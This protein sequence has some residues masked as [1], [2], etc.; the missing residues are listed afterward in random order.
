MRSS[1][2]VLRLLDTKIE[3]TLTCLR[4]YAQGVIHHMVEYQEGVPEHAPRTTLLEHY[5][6]GTY[7]SPLGIH[8][9]VV[10]TDCFD[11]KP[12]TIQMFS[13]F[14]GVDNENPYKH[15]DEFEEMCSTVKMT[16]FSDETLRLKLF[17][18]SLKDHAKH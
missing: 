5:I 2:S 17:P 3:R 6:S 18:F 1:S 13:I 4:K 9:W 8:L 7:S 10:T 16:Q 14:H 11:I 12:S 15:L